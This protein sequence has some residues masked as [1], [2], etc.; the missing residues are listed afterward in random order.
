[1]DMVNQIRE[2]YNTEIEK[3]LT[4]YAEKLFEIATSSTIILLTNQK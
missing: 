1:M 3:L 4:E 2:K